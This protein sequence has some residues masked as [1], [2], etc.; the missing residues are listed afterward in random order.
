MAT[1]ISTNLNDKLIAQTALESFVADMEGLA[2]FTTSYSSEVVRRGATVEVPLV[3]N[4]TATTFADD[5]T[6][7]GGTLGN[8]SVSVNQH[9]IVSVSISDTEYSKSSVAEVT[10]F[11]TQ[12]GKALAQAVLESVYSLFV[13]TASSAAQYA[14]TLTNLSAFTITNARSL[15]KALSDAKVPQTDRNLI[16]NTSLYDS[17]LS[18]SG[19]LDA[20]AF[21][22]RDAIVDG[23]VPRVLG[24][25]VYES[26]VLP[27]NSISLSGLAVHPNAVAIAVRA[28]EPQAPSEYLAASTVTDPQTGLTI[29]V[30]RFYRP[31]TG[32]HH[33]AFE[34]VWGASRAITAAAKL[35][36]GA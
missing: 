33:M 12:A 17:L 15:R 16:L 26:L 9:K 30:R 19:L 29:G 21:G 28:L 35:A 32:K 1:S 2:L 20:G 23:R 24:M 27:T 7:D 13:T 6:A 10:K 25:N 3:A 4:L 36:L 5:Y 31:E 8:V 14:A 34:A 22:G 18:Q 11:S